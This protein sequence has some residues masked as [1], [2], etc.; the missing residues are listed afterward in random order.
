MKTPH[1][2]D[3]T[4]AGIRSRC[5]SN[6]R[7]FRGVEISAEAA[8]LVIRACQATPPPPGG[9]LGAALGDGQRGDDALLDEAV[10]NLPSGTRA[11]WDWQ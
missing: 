5:C 4:S 7:A 2:I 3:G 10:P 11:E 8:T 6:R 9:R 1:C